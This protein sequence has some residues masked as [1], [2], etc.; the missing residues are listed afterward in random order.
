M[1]HRSNRL[2]F[3]AK[4]GDPVAGIS[5]DCPGGKYAYESKTRAKRAAKQAKRDGRPI[6]AVYSCPLCPGWHMTSE[7]QFARTAGRSRP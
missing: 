2:P 3:G 4:G 6:T 1:S 5:F 7:P